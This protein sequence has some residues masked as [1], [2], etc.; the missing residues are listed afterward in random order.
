MSN[1]SFPTNATPVKLYWFPLSG[2]AHRAQLMLSLLEIPY[3]T[4]LVDL[5]T[6]EQ[7]TPEHLMRHPFGQVPVIDDNGVVIWDSNA[8]LTYLARTYDPARTWLPKDTVAAAQVQ[9]WLSI[10]NSLLVDGPAKARL[11]K[12]FGAGFDHDETL[13]TCTDLLTIVDNHLKNSLYLASDTPT[14]ADIAFYTYV[15]HAPEGHVDITS[16]TAI[17]NWISRIEALPH[18][19][20]MIRTET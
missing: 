1:P 9:Q 19:V 20:A 10:S 16:Y 18:F 13:Q 2:H 11:V 6:G 7:K 12:V 14:I 8:I 4:I 17:N 3:E 15:A 5:K